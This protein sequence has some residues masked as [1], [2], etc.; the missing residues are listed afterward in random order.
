MTT[1]P[2]FDG[3][4][5]TVLHLIM[6]ERGQG[7]SFFERS[8][9]GHIDLPR[10][11][12]SNF[13]GGFFAMFVP[14][15]KKE[16]DAL[17]KKFQA[18]PDKAPL[19][20]MLK[21][22]YAQQQAHKMMRTLFDVEAQSDGA[23]KITRTVDEIAQCIDDGTLAMILH[24]E[25]AE[26]ID[27]DL[28]ALEVFYQAGLR[29]LG[30]VWSRPNAFATGVP[31]AFPASPDIGDGLTDA[32]V[33]LVK[34]CNEMGIMI[35]LSH[36]NEKGF[37]DVAKH[38]DAPLVATHSNVHAISAT[39]RNLTDKQLDA[40]AE[41]QGMVGLNF[42]TGFLRPD[43]GKGLSAEER[44]DTPLA[45]MVQH[46]DYLVERIG[47]DCVGLGSDFDGAGIPKEIGDVTGVPNLISAL[48]DAGYDDEAL[49]KITHQNWL[50]LL[51]A[52]WK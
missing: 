52:T 1:F 24:F 2:V 32:G 19:P 26:P 25:G 41:R 21:L 43:G 16:Q 44:K 50:R 22:D 39:P 29:S 14:N 40:I 15:P 49:N 23:V 51:R 17:M 38:S 5:D 13:A 35:D 28:D 4:N 30:L 7:R 46:I 42:A 8:E 36:L 48:Q 27:T 10:A 20:P 33:A 45:V 11:Q 12:E 6:T 37:W 9:V 34:A 47:I 3:H 18:D 31:F